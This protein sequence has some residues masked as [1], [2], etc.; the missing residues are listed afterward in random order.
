MNI[1]QQVFASIDPKASLLV[2]S[3][4][5]S[6]GNANLQKGKIATQ[7]SNN[8]SIKAQKPAK[9][10]K[11]LN[12]KDQNRVNKLPQVSINQSTASKKAA[13]KSSLS[14]QKYSTTIQNIQHQTK[15]ES[16]SSSNTVQISQEIPPPKIQTQTISQ[17]SQVDDNQANQL[18]QK[19]S[20]SSVSS[21]NNLKM[22][23]TQ[24]Q[25]PTPEA[26]IQ[27]TA[28]PK[29]SNGNQIGTIHYISKI[30]KR[31][32]STSNPKPQ[33][34]QQSSNCENDKDSYDED[35]ILSQIK[36]LEAKYE[37]ACSQ[38]NNISGL[39]CKAQTQNDRLIAENLELEIQIQELKDQSKESNRRIVEMQ[40]NFDEKMKE[41][42][43]SWAFKVDELQM[44][45]DVL[46]E[47]TKE[48]E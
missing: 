36:K 47:S 17:S 12:S 19:L 14:Q 26:R 18:D 38:L 28:K 6:S 35:K 24:T 31:P 25:T 5:N 4:E 21:Q 46:R 42:N 29:E 32:R 33:C 30:E 23:F 7:T 3:S 39:Y 1:F 43:A 20:I 44:Q 15:M 8:L 10:E 37:N 22:C 2:K 13:I 27:E 45:L 16:V 41:K 40:E 9:K 11:Q 34:Q 48:C